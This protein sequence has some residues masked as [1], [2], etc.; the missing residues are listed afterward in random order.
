MTIMNEKD[1]TKA[2]KF[3]SYSKMANNL[4]LRSTHTYNR[5][6]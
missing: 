1:R 4:I 5:L 6:E 3:L 2:H